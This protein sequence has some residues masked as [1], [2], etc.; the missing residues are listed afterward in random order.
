MGN[1]C[2]GDWEL[3]EAAQAASAKPY[4]LG[5]A[6]LNHTLDELAELADLAGESTSGGRSP[7]QT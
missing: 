1:A 5:D 2:S 4:Q 6:A 7:R 3:N